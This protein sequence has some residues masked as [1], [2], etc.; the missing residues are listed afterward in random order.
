MRVFALLLGCAAA[1]AGLP[2]HAQSS[3]TT[4]T[5]V[6][7]Q[8][9]V[10]SVLTPEL[11]VSSLQEVQSSLVQAAL[12]LELLVSMERMEQ[13]VAV[14]SIPARAGSYSLLGTANSS[15]PSRLLVQI[16]LSAISI[17]WE[18]TGRDW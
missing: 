16:S 9:D 15:R 10:K 11:D 12:F 1:L 4:E 17:V 3:A 18:I 8:S 14:V 5:S 7:D 6:L 13:E 2:A